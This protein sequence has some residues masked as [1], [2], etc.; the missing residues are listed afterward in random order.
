[1][2]NQYEGSDLQI[3]DTPVLEYYSLNGIS[4]YAFIGWEALSLV[5]FF[6]VALVV[7]LFSI[8]NHVRPHPS[9]HDPVMHHALPSC[10]SGTP[11]TVADQLPCMLCMPGCAHRSAVFCHP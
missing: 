8:T 2:I 5:V 7:R 4:K 10:F 6:L 1:M 11:L 3:Y 9:S